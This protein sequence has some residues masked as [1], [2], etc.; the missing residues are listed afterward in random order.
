[1]E[2]PSNSETLAMDDVFTIKVGMVVAIPMRN[3]RR[4]L[5]QYSATVFAINKN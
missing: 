2:E 4:D 1:M 3:N 5:N